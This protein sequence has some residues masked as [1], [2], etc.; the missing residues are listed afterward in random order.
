MQ[1]N[2]FCFFIAE[3]HSEASRKTHQ[4]HRD[5][6][7]QKLCRIRTF[8][9]HRA[10]NGGRRLYKK[11]PDSLGNLTN[12]SLSTV[13]LE[14]LSPRIRN[15]TSRWIELTWQPPSNADSLGSDLL[16]YRVY[17]EELC[18][19]HDAHHYRNRREECRE[20]SPET[21]HGAQSLWASFDNLGKDPFDIK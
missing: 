19:H 18:H 1:K 9:R 8:S 2:R 15:V 12:F 3:L 5:G 6:G 16:G 20:I 21:V 13:P 7:G 10:S 14:P 4:L 17:V 11:Q